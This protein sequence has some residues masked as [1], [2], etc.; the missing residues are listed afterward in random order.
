MTRGLKYSLLAA[1][2]RRGI[3]AGSW[4][5]GEKLP[6]QDELAA[7]RGL[8]INSVRRA[9]D[10][11]IDEGLVERRQGAGT[12]VC[13]P[14]PRAR[15][16]QRRV[17]VLIPDT[18][19]Y[20]PRVLAGLE[21]TLARLGMAT[22][23]A[24]YE[25]DPG[26]QDAALQSLLSRDL[27]G[28]VCTPALSDWDD[29]WTRLDELRAR[30]PLVLVERRLADW[31]PDDDFDHVCSDHRAGAID[32]IR[33]LARLGHH[34]IGLVARVQPVTAPEVRQG[35][36][37]ACEHL[38]LEPTVWSVDER[39]PQQ[40]GRAIDEIVAAGLTAVLVHGDQEASVLVDR[41]L[42]RRRRTPGDLAIV[43][44]DDETADLARVPLSAVAPPKYR[45][46]R[47]A[48]QL[49]VDRMDEGSRAPVQQVLIRPRLIV[50]ASCGAG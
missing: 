7:S 18:R 13:D 49:I 10:E 34:R 28:L 19:L 39:W 43:S 4:V 14:S 26:R 33:H 17:G 16:G 36:L 48:A 47:V 44:Y 1:D 29:P 20:Y 50:R 38:G 6:T 24:T 42:E 25:N 12:F 9:V 8:S 15:A 35:Y 5:A 30:L 23:V 45:L 22:S 21:T 2:L 31:G 46:G 11:L 27:D 40:V 32:A 41:W 3:L 37:W